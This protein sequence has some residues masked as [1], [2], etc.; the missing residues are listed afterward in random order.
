[1]SQSKRTYLHYVFMGLLGSEHLRLDLEH[2]SVWFTL[3]G[4]SLTLLHR[5]SVYYVQCLNGSKQTWTCT[6]SAVVKHTLV[7]FDLVL[8]VIGS[9]PGQVVMSALDWLSIWP[10]GSEVLD[11]LRTLICPSET[12][13]LLL[14]AKYNQLLRNTSSS[15]CHSHPVQHR[16]ESPTVLNS[17]RGAFFVSFLVPLRCFFCFCCQLRGCVQHSSR[18]WQLSICRASPAKQTYEFQ[19]AWSHAP[20][21][22][23]V[24][25]LKRSTHSKPYKTYRSGALCPKNKIASAISHYSQP[26]QPPSLNHFPLSTP[27]FPWHNPSGNQP[28][29]I[30]T[31]FSVFLSNNTLCF[32]H[33]L[34]HLLLCSLSAFWNWL[35]FPVIAGVT[36]TL[37]LS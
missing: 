13:W 11:L 3:I 19:T 33:P 23:E 30:N 36:L 27:L 34:F 37:C 16:A 32:L 28:V 8:P 31:G 24:E 12:R 29:S 6:L 15:G 21:F 25:Y 18:L 14:S 10:F 20:Y 26:H 9:S 35:F 1:M 7:L 2:K 4:S 17:N 5:R 22:I